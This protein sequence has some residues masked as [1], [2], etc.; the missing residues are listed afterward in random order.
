VILRPMLAT[1]ASTLPAGP[2][3][4]YEVKWDGYRAIAVR[5]G[6]RVQLLSRNE[7][8]LTRDFP[9]VVSALDTVEAP[10]FTLDGEIVALDTEG[11]P[12]FQALQHR[13]TAGLAVVYYAFDLL[14]LNG[15]ALVRIPLGER[16]RR[17]AEVVK[18]SRILL[19]E[20]LDGSPTQIEREI[21]RLGLE[22]IVAKR[23]DS[24]YRP[25]E[26]SPAWV[27]VKFS[28]RQE[29]VIGG[30]KPDGRSFESVLVGY[31]HDKL[32]HY[33][34]KVR[35]GLTPHLKAELFERITKRP[36]ARCPFGDL[37]NAG[38]GS[39]WR[40]GITEADMRTL[41]WVKPRVVV[42]VAFV[43]WTRD[44]LLRHPQFVGIRTDRR[45]LTVVRERGV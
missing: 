42:D 31:Y 12:S 27:K 45:P 8:S 7:K 2:E 38:R 13:A 26:R 14:D 11:R 6:R 33:A 28:P 3:W 25:G 19:S 39:H 1:P 35:A 5:D 37:P 23:R 34:A 36:A 24:L 30:Y 29:F 40:E 32:L 22:G 15:D 20:P 21:R 18:G 17:L 41:R 9:T 43:E 44:G 16:R 10:R 4:T